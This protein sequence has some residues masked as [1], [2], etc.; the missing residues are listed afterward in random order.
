MS[1][2]DGPA[3]A[4]TLLPRWKANNGRHCHENSSQF[5]CFDLP[6]PILV[7][8]GLPGGELP[9][10]EGS[11]GGSRTY[12]LLDAK[13][14]MDAGIVPDMGNLA[15]YKGHGIGVILSTESDSPMNGARD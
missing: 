8:R 10:Q 3:L 1:G 11:G 15:A 14:K 7:A 5:A 13:L 12:H 6:H 9:S 4:K 2:F